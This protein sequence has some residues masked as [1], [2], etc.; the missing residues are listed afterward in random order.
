MAV[1]STSSVHKGWP[2]LVSLYSIEGSHQGAH[3]GI[4]RAAV[5]VST[6]IDNIVITEMVQNERPAAFGG[7]HKSEYRTEISLHTIRVSVSLVNCAVRLENVRRV[8][9]SKDEHGG[10]LCGDAGP[11][12]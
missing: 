9:A 7:L 12:R 5:A 1:P 8:G 6:T 10:N 3:N 2:F 11:Q 4:L